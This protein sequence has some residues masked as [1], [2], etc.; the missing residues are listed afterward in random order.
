MNWKNLRKQSNP[1]S[2]TNDFKKIQEPLRGAKQR[3][4]P[5][6]CLDKIEIA[7]PAFGRL[8]MTK[9]LEK[10][11]GIASDSEAISYLYLI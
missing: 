6:G 10:E 4:N 5:H 7:T 8:A 3:S 1:S 2:S 9:G 11:I